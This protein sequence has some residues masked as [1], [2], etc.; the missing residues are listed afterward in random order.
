MAGQELTEFYEERQ[1]RPASKMA[2]DMESHKPPVV[3]GS[4]I[5]LA[6]LSSVIITFEDTVVLRDGAIVYRS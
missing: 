6:Y 3:F 4:A 2:L 1:G 5:S